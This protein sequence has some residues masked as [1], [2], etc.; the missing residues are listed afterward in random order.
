MQEGTRHTDALALAAGKCTAQLT[1]RGIIALGQAVDKA[2]QRSLFAGC[3]H[4]FPGGI[5]LCN[6]D[7]V[8]NGIVEQLGLLRHKAFL[9]AQGGGVHAADILCAKADA[10]AGYIPEAH[11][12]PQEGRL[13]AVLSLGIVGGTTIRIIADGADEQAAVDGLI[14]LVESGFAE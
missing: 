11:Q 9:F 10:A 5:P 1:H 12:Q 8:L 4:L 14:K 2:V 6:A 3:F 13:S 7:V